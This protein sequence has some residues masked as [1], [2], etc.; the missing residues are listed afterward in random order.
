MDPVSQAAL[1][2]VVGQIA[3]HRHLGPKS[4]AVG[5]VAGLLPDIDVLFSINGD[6]FDQLVLHRGI[7]HSLFFAPVVGPV[8][9]WAVWAWERRRTRDRP[10]DRGRLYA[11]MWVAGLALLSH[12]LLDYLTPYGTQLLLPFTDTRFAINA[13]PII[14]PVY[15]LALL[16]GLFVSRKVPRHA[17][18]V[19]AITLALSSAYLGYGWHL[20]EAAVQE[21]RRQLEAVGV[22]PVRLAAFPTILQV[23]YRRVVARTAQQDRVGFISMWEPCAIDWGAA[24]RIHPAQTQAFLAAREGRIYDWFSMGWAHYESARDGD[25]HILRAHDLRYGMDNNPANSLFTAQMVHQLGAAPTFTSQSPMSSP[26]QRALS[27]GKLFADTY[28]P[29]CRMREGVEPVAGS[30]L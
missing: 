2:A 16:I 22:E 18:R 28:A 12:P 17:L 11:W 7:T 27:L 26:S 13:M 9:G 29:W 3:G 14:D 23:H 1:G 4:A 21:A 5:A 10:P 25:T 20:N 24:P 15:T 6:Y 19:A 30:P 8:L